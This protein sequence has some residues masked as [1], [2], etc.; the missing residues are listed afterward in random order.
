MNTIHMIPS[1]CVYGVLNCPI[2]EMI[3]NFSY[4]FSEYDYWGAC[5]FMVTL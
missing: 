4:E 2:I 1:V 5:V 3:S